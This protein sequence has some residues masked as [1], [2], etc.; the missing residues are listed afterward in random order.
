[1]IFDE[2]IVVRGGGDLATGTIHKLHRCGFRVLVLETPEPTSIRRKVSFSEAIYEGKIQVEGITAVHVKDLNEMMKT[3]DNKNIPVMID[4]KGTYIQKLKARVVVDAILAKKNLG[5]TKD[6][7]E[8]TI[9]LGPGFTAGVDVDVVIETSRGHNLGRLI[10][11]GEAEKNTGIPGVVGGY[12]KERVFYSP[13]DGK[14]ENIKDIGEIVEKDE[15]IAYVENMPIKATMNGVLRGIIRN[16]SEVKAGLKIADIDPRI[17]E[18]TNCY[19][20]SDKSRNI[21]GG[22]LEAIFYMKNTFSER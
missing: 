13:C 5:T 6:M 10:F 4:P 8:I 16:R 18:K 3:W 19:T 20:I 17:S 9:A 7:A 2:I 1:M 22:V 15:V 14:I 12:S 21:A 11:E